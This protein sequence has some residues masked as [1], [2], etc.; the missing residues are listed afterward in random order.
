MVANKV[1]IDEQY[2]KAADGRQQYIKYLRG[3]RI[4]YKERCVA[5]CYWCNGY[6]ADGKFDC[7]VKNCPLYTLMPYKSM[8]READE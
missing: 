2:M 4:G 1:V 3:E 6:Y 5:M 7:G 8:P